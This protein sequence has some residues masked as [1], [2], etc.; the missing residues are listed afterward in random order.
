MNTDESEPEPHI[1]F[2][3]TVERASIM[4]QNV[5]LPIPLG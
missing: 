3:E 4:S 5:E 1:V 2:N